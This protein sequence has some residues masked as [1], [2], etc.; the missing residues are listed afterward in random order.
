LGVSLWSP[1]LPFHINSFFWIYDLMLLIHHSCFQIQENVLNQGFFL[2]NSAL[3][4]S[5]N[6]LLTPGCTMD[7]SIPDVCYR[8]F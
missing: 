8:E 2:K 7:I 3:N 5:N 6:I 4:K 1:V